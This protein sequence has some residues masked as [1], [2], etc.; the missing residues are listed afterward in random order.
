MLYVSDNYS[1]PC[2]VYLSGDKSIN[3][4]KRWLVLLQIMKILIIFKGV[5]LLVSDPG[6]VTQ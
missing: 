4:K 5:K 1:T 2:P 6:G 3:G